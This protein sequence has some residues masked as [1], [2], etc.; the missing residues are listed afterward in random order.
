MNKINIVTGTV[1]LTAGLLAGCSSSSNNNN[2]PD[3]DPIVIPAPY[4]RVSNLTAQTATIS[5]ADPDGTP[6]VT[7]TSQPADMTLS[8]TV[9]PVSATELTL[10]LGLTNNASRPLSNPKVVVDEGASTLGTAVLTGT[11]DY[12]T[13]EEFVSLGNIVAAGASTV[14]EDSDSMTLTTIDT[15]DPIVL[16][17]SVPTQDVSIVATGRRDAYL[18]LFD[19]GTGEAKTRVT[20]SGYKFRAPGAGG[21]MWMRQAAR[22]PDGEHIYTDHTSLSIVMVLNLLTGELSHYPIPVDGEVGSVTGVAVAPTGQFVYA[23]QIDG[24]H[25][26]GSQIEADRTTDDFAFGTNLVKIS[27]ASGQIVS[28][29]TIPGGAAIIEGL[30]GNPPETGVSGER[31]GAIWGINVSADGTRGSTSFSRRFGGQAGRVLLF[32]LDAM[33]IIGD[34]EAGA[35]AEEIR[36]TAISP[37]NNFIYLGTHRNGGGLYVLDVATGDVTNVASVPNT[38]TTGLQFDEDGNLYWATRNSGDDLTIFTFTGNDYSAPTG[39]TAFD[40]TSDPVAFDLGPYGDFYYICTASADLVKVDKATDTA[41][42]ENIN[43]TDDFRHLCVA[44]AY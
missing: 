34:F 1:I 10:D 23:S 15:T 27:T 39:N 16:E 2:D 37:D 38:R 17:V 6:V 36:F 3:P 4:A 33:T 11:G 7:I 25:W 42:Y 5:I 35:G 30:P 18:E 9:T 29:L 41:V 28:K 12:G 43:V 31:T 13:D 19:G 21:D 22:S 8:A 24:D 14:A 40:F 20:T 26:Q 32:D 44:S